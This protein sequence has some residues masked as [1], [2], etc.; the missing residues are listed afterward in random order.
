MRIEFTKFGLKRDYRGAHVSYRLSGRD[1]LATIV[2]CHRVETTGCI[3]LELQ[4]FNGEP[5]P[6]V[7]AS[8]VEL[9]ER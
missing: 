2:G 3:M 1:Y 9:L 8:F 4:H 5:A 6:S 7:A